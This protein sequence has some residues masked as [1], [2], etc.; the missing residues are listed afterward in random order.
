MVL[1]CV[2]HDTAFQRDGT[3]EMSGLPLLLLDCDC[4]CR[5]GG[6]CF[7]VAGAT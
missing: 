7:E 5:R 1:I 2:W 6:G 4:E 3:A